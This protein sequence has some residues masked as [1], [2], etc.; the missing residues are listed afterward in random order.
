MFNILHSLYNFISILNFHCTNFYNQKIY[1]SI[2]KYVSILYLNLF[3]Y[4]Q[5]VNRFINQ[6]IIFK[7]LIFS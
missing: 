7:A 4:F 2:I 5:L 1:E 6:L 3:I